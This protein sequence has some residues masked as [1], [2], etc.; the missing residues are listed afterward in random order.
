MVMRHA[1]VVFVSY[2]GYLSHIIDLF[3]MS[4]KSRLLSSFVYH[5]ITVTFV[6]KV[7]PFYFHMLHELREQY[8]T[9]RG[10]YC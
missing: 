2:L 9:I 7:A 3:L 1:F 4:Y 5:V 8:K 6:S 10:L